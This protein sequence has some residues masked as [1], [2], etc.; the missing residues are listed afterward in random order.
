MSEIWVALLRAINVGGKNKLPMKDLSAMFAEAGCGSVTTYIQSGNVIFEAPSGLCARL[1]GLIEK[2]IAEQ[3]G[4]R[5]PV[6]L[7]SA[8]QLRAVTKNNPFL[9][10]G[11]PPEA[12]FV[13]FLAG[14]PEQ[15]RIDSLD[16]DRSP[17][18]KFVV[19]G[20]EIYLHLLNGA[21]KTKLTNV[22]FDAKLA[23]ISTARNWRTVT[24]L[25]DMMEKKP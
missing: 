17:P 3:F 23:T 11:A 7:R 12:T 4:Y 8:K 16:P 18:D 24:T 25:A 6:V 5:T 10:A 9:N 21:A 14:R 20:Q 1:P 22:W 19:Q 15:E 13:L 2:R